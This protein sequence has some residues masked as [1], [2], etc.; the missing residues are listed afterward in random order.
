MPVRVDANLGSLVTGRISG[1]LRRCSLKVDKNILCF[2]CWKMNGPTKASVFEYLVNKVDYVIHL[3]IK[4]F[5]THVN[6]GNK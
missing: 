5:H 6:Y 4:S 3:F 1:I 2:V